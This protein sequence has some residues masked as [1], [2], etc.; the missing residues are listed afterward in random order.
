MSNSIVLPNGN[1]R[2]LGRN[3]AV[4][5]S[6]RLSLKNYLSKTTPVVAPASV[7]YSPAA[8]AALAQM[9]L[10]DTLGDCVIA[11]IAH[12]IGLF[13]GNAGQA[14]VQFTSAQITAMYSAIGGYIPGNPSTDNGCNET[15]AL[16]YWQQHGFVG[17]HQIAGWLAIDPTNK[18]EV[19]AAMYLFENLFFGVELPD[20]WTQVTGP[21]FVWDVGTPNPN[22]GHCFVGAGY[23]AQGIEVSTW[24]MLGTL[25]WAALNTDVS[26]QDGGELYVVLSPE[27]INRATA[28]T[29]N[30]LNW[31]QLVADI[32]ALGGNIPVPPAPAPTPPAP[33]P[34]PAAGPTQAQVLAAVTS[35]INGVFTLHH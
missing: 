30:G 18:A 31:S 20:A 9:Y 29:P 8:A 13:T 4:A 34:V 21:G 24:G 35:A 33:T 12:L 23:N 11:G 7:N 26:S 25:T 32:N 2:H 15:T 5:R 22:N 16:N 27:I 28:K 6:P 1:I 14:P 19:Q 10:N 3:R 17:G